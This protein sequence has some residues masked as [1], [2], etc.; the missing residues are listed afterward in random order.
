MAVVGKARGATRNPSIRAVRGEE[1]RSLFG[2]RLRGSCRQSRMGRLGK[3]V[4]DPHLDGRDHHLPS[5]RDGH[6]LS[7]S[8]ERPRH[9]GYGSF[10]GQRLRD[11]SLAPRR[12]RLHRAARRRHR[13]R[14]VGHPVDAPH[15]LAGEATRRLPTHAE[16]LDAGLQRSAAPRPCRAPEGRPHR[17]PERSADVADRGADGDGNR[18]GTRGLA[19]GSFRDARKVLAQG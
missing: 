5:L 2:Y 16:L 7:L 17:L 9:P 1:T 4:D 15:C 11:R 18:L 13:Y 8:T 6:R 3:E 19:R 14:I 10:Q 12:R